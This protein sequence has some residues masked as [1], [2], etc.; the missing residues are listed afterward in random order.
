[1][2]GTGVFP[3]NF[4]IF[5]FPMSAVYIT[6]YITYTN[7]YCIYICIYAYLPLTGIHIH[8]IYVYIY[9]YMPVNGK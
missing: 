3:P 6:L 5:T 4:F 7:I 9:I 1:M 2:G 8:T